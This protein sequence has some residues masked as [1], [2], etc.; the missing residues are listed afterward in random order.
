[1]NRLAPITLAAALALFAGT[2]VA[3]TVSI[4]LPSDETPAVLATPDA[5]IV[6]VT[7][8]ACHSL[9]YLTTQPRGKG[10]QF[11]RDSVTKMVN[12]YGAPIAPEDAA[13]ISAILARKFG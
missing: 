2:A 7:C 12:V 1:M 10:E 8:S 13:E 11:W 3:R 4:D 9:D 5:E 6:A